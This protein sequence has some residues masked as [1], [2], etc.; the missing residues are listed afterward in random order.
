MALP[1]REIMSS[2]TFRFEVGTSSFEVHR[3]AITKESPVL[4][5]LMNGS[6]EE[7]RQGVARLEDV[8]EETFVRFTQFAYTGDYVPPSFQIAAGAEELEKSNPYASDDDPWK[9]IQSKGKKKS[10]SFDRFDEGEAQRLFKNVEYELPRSRTALLAACEARPN[11]GSDEDYTPVFLGHAEL[12]VFA[13]QYGIKD[14][15]TLVLHK[16]HRLLV[17]FSAYESRVTDI[18]ALVRYTYTNTPFC[19]NIADQFREMVLLYVAS[20]FKKIGRSQDFVDLVAEGGSFAAD[21]IL[22]LQENM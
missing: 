3:A 13:D 1:F 10:H 12:Y 18:V 16:L 2:P 7:A 14:L 4:D 5:K 17:V 15:K 6:M 21:L 11:R 9:L 8:S 20:Q 22:K 19:D